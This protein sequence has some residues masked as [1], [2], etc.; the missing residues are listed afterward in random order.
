M[1]SLNRVQLIGNLG[2]DPEPRY[3]PNG[4]AVCTVSLATSSARNDKQSGER[5]EDTEWHRVVFYGKLAEVVGEHM[6]K[7]RSMYLE[8][9]LQTRKWTDR[10]GVERYATEI[11][12]N[13]MQMLGGGKA[14]GE[15][16]A[17]A[18]PRTPAPAFADED[19]PF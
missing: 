6:R 4:T 11:V 15:R 10:D 5:I 1:A 18:A 9:R 16:A 19:V 14:D 13:E 2:R 7:G 3:T 12:A 17:T 8:G